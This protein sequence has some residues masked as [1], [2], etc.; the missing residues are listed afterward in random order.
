MKP[1]SFKSSSFFGSAIFLQLTFRSCMDCPFTL[2]WFHAIKHFD[3]SYSCNIPENS[4]RFFMINLATVYRFQSMMWIFSRERQ[5]CQCVL[6]S[7]KAPKELSPFL[8]LSNLLFLVNS[9][10]FFTVCSCY[11]VVLGLHS[12]QDSYWKEHRGTVQRV[13]IS[14][15]ALALHS[16]WLYC[17]ESPCI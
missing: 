7:L 13:H 5:Y 15:S 4:C 10:L 1:V 11:H 9:F 2:A 3:S 17:L 14:Q 8:S 12:K 6:E 16:R